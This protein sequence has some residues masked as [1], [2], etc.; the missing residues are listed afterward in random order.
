M[1]THSSLKSKPLHRKKITP[2]NIRV[3]LHEHDARKQHRFTVTL[4][5]KSNDHFIVESPTGIGKKETVKQKTITLVCCKNELYYKCKD[6]KYR[7]IK[8]HDISIAGSGD[9]IYLNDTCYHGSIRFV[10]DRP[11]SKLP[12]VNT[13]NLDDYIYSV[14]RFECI[15]S[16]PMEMQ[17]VQAVTSRTYAA[18]LLQQGQKKNPLHHYYDIKNTNFHQIYKGSHNYAHLREAVEQTNGQIMTYKNSV[19][20]AMFDACCSGIIPAHVSNHEHSNKPYLFRKRQCKHCSNC[21]LYNWKE[22]LDSA[23]LLEKL[24]N[25]YKTG[26]KFKNF[27]N[28]LIDIKIIDKDEAGLVH[29]VKLFGKRKTVTLPG[30]DLRLVVQGK[31]KSLSFNVKKNKNR[32]VFNGKGFGHQL[33]LC[34]WGAKELIKKGWKYREVLSFYFPHIKISKLT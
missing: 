14:L 34:Q 29:Q 3:L 30:H 25:H 5:P 12:V 10:I 18:Y 1:F 22:E 28:Q 32:F 9:K 7:R 26:A 15:T 13:V 11:T 6:C 2:K 27:G 33:G 16:W 21:N 19:V 4:D 17:K 20:L 8:H 24:K 23:Q 31:M